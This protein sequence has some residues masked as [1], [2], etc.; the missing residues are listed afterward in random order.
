MK[1]LRKFSS[2]KLSMP[3]VCVLEVF[4]WKF[5]GFIRSFH[6]KISKDFFFVYPHQVWV[7]LRLDFMQVKLQYFFR[8]CWNFTFTYIVHFWFD[9]WASG[10]KG[11]KEWS[12]KSFMSF[13][14]YNKVLNN[15]FFKLWGRSDINKPKT[16]MS[17][18]I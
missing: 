9:S 1:N 13:G 18:F 2:T 6:C 8:F 5:I 3:Y 14:W 7:Y 16:F 12:W 10:L 4:L 15:L 11:S 17:Y